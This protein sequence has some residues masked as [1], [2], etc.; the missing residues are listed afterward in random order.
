M[1]LPG[2]TAWRVMAGGE[3][4]L[5]RLTRPELQVLQELSMNASNGEIAKELRFTVE[6]VENHVLHI[7]DKLELVTRLDAVR[8]ALRS[9][10]R[11]A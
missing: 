4:L 9:G 8:Y 5:D 10:L 2:M 7:L 3:T 6:V 1:K 11:A